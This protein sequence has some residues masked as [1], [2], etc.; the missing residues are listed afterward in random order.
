MSERWLF[1]FSSV[2]QPC[3][4]L[5][6]HEL[7][8]ASFKLFFWIFYLSAFKELKRVRTLLWNTFWPKGILWLVWTSIQVT[9][10]F[11]YQQWSCFTL[12]FMCSLEWYFLFP[13]R[14]FL[15]YSQLNW[16]VH[17]AWLLVFLLFDMPSLLWFIIS[18]FWFKGRDLWLFLSL[19]HLEAMVGLFINQF[20]YCCALGNRERDGTCWSVEQSEHTH[21]SIKFITLYGHILLLKNNYSSSIKEP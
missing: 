5:C 17:M 10:T 14:T 18:S 21:L 9:K 19:E 20:Q 12:P 11:S 15:F 13:S 6:D 2:A 7:T 4:T 3:P 1:P 16:L 8:S